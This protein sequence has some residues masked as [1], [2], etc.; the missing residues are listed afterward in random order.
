MPISAHVGGAHGGGAG[1][2]PELEEFRGM[3]FALICGCFFILIVPICDHWA[4][5]LR[6]L[7]MD[8]SNWH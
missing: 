3:A 2:E 4:T 6:H 1:R 5:N 8:Q 7:A